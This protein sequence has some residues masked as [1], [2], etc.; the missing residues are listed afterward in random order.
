MA[1]EKRKVDLGV[2]QAVE[3]TLPDGT[4]IEVSQEDAG[5]FKVFIPSG[6]KPVI[7]PGGYGNV[8][9]VSLWP[10]FQPVRPPTPEQPVIVPRDLVRQVMAPKH[11]GV[12][13]DAID[14][15]QTVIDTNERILEI[16]HETIRATL[17]KRPI[18]GYEE[19][20]VRQ[21]CAL[22]KVKDTDDEPVTRWNGEWAHD[23]CREKRTAEQEAAEK[24]RRIREDLC[25][26][27]AQARE[28]I[29]EHSGAVNLQ[30]GGWMH[31]EPCYG[32]AL[33]EAEKA[34]ATV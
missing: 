12:G 30:T 29:P 5:G 3:I 33:D 20:V 13:G 17:T 2:G 22:C 34:D 31:R 9:D 4:Q 19:V 25:V 16:L 28:G 14:A 26:Y 32:Y 6:D 24:T 18:G 7:V 23:A 27:C 15:V 8:L 21:V 10:T 1:R 11:N